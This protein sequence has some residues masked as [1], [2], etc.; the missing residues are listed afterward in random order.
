MR[1][2][3]AVCSSG[4]NSTSC[5]R[6]PCELEQLRAERVR[7]ERGEPLLRQPVLEERGQH[8]AP[9]LPVRLLLA[10]R[11]CQDHVRLP[12]NRLRE[13][14]VRGR[15]ARVQADDEIDLL[16]RIEAADFAR[17][18]RSPVST[19]AGRER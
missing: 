1:T 13:R 9:D 12:A 14:I 2:F 19:G 15:V 16:A 7:H 4:T 18:K 5:A 6:Y 11:D 3:F 10:A 17:W 8:R